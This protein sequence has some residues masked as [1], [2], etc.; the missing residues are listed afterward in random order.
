MRRTLLLPHLM[1]IFLLASLPGCMTLNSVV[2]IQETEL[3][4]PD[5]NRSMVVFGVGVEGIWEHPQFAVVLDEYDIGLQSITGNCWRYN[6]MEASV[7]KDSR[8]VQ[9]FAFEVKPGHYSFSGF[10]PTKL[11]GPNAFS[12]PAG[13]VVY[14]GDF[15]YSDEHTVVLRRNGDTTNNELLKGFPVTTDKITLAEAI[16]VVAP[17]KF[18]CAP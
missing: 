7:P 12:V 4:A 10:N 5:I 6:K 3:A 15:I 16:S 11:V 9:R 14:L 17:Q 2:R 13:Q 18:L 1:S 8:A